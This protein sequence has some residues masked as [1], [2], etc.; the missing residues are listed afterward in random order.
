MSQAHEQVVVD[1]HGLTVGTAHGATR[2]A[3]RDLAV[4]CVTASPH[5]V[6]RT[7]DVAFV[8]VDRHG[9]SLQVS[10]GAAGV[11]THLLGLHGFDSAAVADVLDADTPVSRTCWRATWSSDRSSAAR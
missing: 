9:S 3:W 1:V 2:L 4:V 5:P 7:L 10:C 8:L 11:L 6:G